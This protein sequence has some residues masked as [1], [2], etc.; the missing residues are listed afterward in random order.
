[1]QTRAPFFALGGTAAL[2]AALGAVA[3]VRG[4]AAPLVAA[5]DTAVVPLVIAGVAALM[6]PPLI[7]GG[8]LLGRRLELGRVLGAAARAL[9]A[10][11][12]L[13]LGLVAPT[14]FLLVTDAGLPLV[15]LGGTVL[16]GAAL[17]ALRVLWVELEVGGWPRRAQGFFAVWS[18]VALTIGACLYVEHL[19]A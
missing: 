7:I 19:I 1:M 10:A 16:A 9:G 13:V 12:V 6:L 11:G 18:L 15:E 2:G 17:A 8:A 5:A 4:P 3:A 14:L